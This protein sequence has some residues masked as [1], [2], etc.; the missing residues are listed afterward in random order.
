VDDPLE[1]TQVVLSRLAELLRALP[2]D[3]IAELYAGTATL[4]VVPKA[5]RSPARRTGSVKGL[6][7]TPEHVEA[8]LRAMGDRA[9]AIR[10]IEELRL[11]VPQL[12]ELAEQLRISVATDARK[13]AVIA[14]IVQWTVGRRL[15]SEAI[16][17]PAP[18]RF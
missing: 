9:A 7:V 18:A 14:D 2:A 15:D 16:S 4:A 10:Y 11:T 13:N 6:P 17:R 5:G 1:I 8:E 12:R 3:Q